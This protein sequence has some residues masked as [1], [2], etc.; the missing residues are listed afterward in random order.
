M[1]GAVMSLVHHE[2]T[3]GMMRF[4]LHSHQSA[5]VNAGHS[6]PESLI[7]FVRNIS[8]EDLRKWVV[9]FKD[10]KEPR[11]PKDESGN[12]DIDAITRQV[13]FAKYEKPEKFTQHPGKEGSLITEVARMTPSGATAMATDL[14]IPGEVMVEILAEWKAHVRERLPKRVAAAIRKELG[15]DSSDPF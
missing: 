8:D 2:S 15:S 9:L 12:W 1:L 7:D 3:T 6:T 5:S 14:T 13:S 4:W 10:K 11:D